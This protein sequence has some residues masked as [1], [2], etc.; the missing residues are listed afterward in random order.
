MDEQVFTPLLDKWDR[1]WMKAAH[2]T[3]SWS[4]D[5]ST[6]VGCVIVEPESQR[7]TGEGFNGFPRFMSD[8][9][10]LYADRETKYARTLH[11]ELNAVLFAKKTEGCTA[12]VTHP[13]CTACSLVLIQSGISRVVAL[14]P[15][16]DLLTRWED[17]IKKAK[18]FF[19]EAEV[20]YELVD[21]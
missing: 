7:R 16:N 14:R 18:G 17:S 21:G 4:K 11:A 20:E 19:D 2:E 5:P 13:P 12:Y 1:R 9:P 15:S 3:A 6:K 10:A 8:D